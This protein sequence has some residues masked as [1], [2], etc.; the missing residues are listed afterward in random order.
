MTITIHQPHDKFFKAN[1]K[2]K[3]IAIDFLK[4]YLEPTLFNKIDVNSLQLT[5]K[6]FIVPQLRE[7][8]S[9]IIYKA[10]INKACSYLFFL[11]EHQSTADPLMAFR[12][13]HAIVSLSYEHLKQGYKKLPII[14]PFCV[15]HGEIS[16]YPHSNCV[17]DCFDDPEFAQEVALKPFKLI[18]LTVLSDEEIKTHGLVGLMEMLFKHQR[19]KNFL[20]FMRQLLK[21]KFIQN[22]IRQLNISYLNDMLDYIAN[23]SEDVSEPQAAQH[24]IQELIQAFPEEA[25]R[26]QIMTFAQQ[27]K[28]EALQQG[29]EKGLEKGR[30]EGRH[31]GILSVAKRLLVEEGMS[32]QA[33]QRLT[34]LPEKEVMDLVN[35]H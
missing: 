24:L 4:T 5:E 32:P 16:P 15:Y 29:L 27:L 12:F 30:E 1:L 34:G 22:I 11:L 25:A 13:L 14:L 26:K 9:D 7:I 21:V 31:E 20:S 33:I 8:H 23:T 35:K 10:L 18:D 6:S 17:Y 2:D 28:Q 3:K 19:N